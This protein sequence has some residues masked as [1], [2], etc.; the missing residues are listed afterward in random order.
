M[1]N[2][3]ENLHEIKKIEVE[4]SF[5]SYYRYALWQFVCKDAWEL[6]EGRRNYHAHILKH[7]TSPLFDV[8]DPIS[9][10][11]VSADNLTERDVQNFI[12]KKY[13]DGPGVHTTTVKLQLLDAYAKIR[14]PEIAAAFQIDAA[15]E[16][17]AEF[18][19]KRIIRNL[20]M[21]VR[22]EID[23]FLNNNEGIY[24]YEERPFS[25]KIF[26]LKH[27]PKKTYAIVHAFI[28]NDSEYSEIG[29][30]YKTENFPDYDR[31]SGV[32]VP[33]VH[34]HCSI[35]VQHAYSGRVIALDS[36][37]FDH[38]GVGREIV[39]GSAR[40]VPEPSR[41]ISKISIKGISSLL[42]GEFDT[43]EVDHKYYL[44]SRRLFEY[45]GERI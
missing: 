11:K 27:V 16:I 34:G 21:Y 32:L 24:V 39:R 12:G 6:G 2:D 4:T 26:L 42:S 45:F 37:F 36:W 43:M 7:V 14:A 23:D 13:T 5:D 8:I 31:Y 25:T 17:Y 18:K 33:D 40:I 10:K 3:V 35:E 44:L 1:T 38:G 20:S 29:S 19:S 28:L 9:Q 15:Q 22:S 30:K 41:S